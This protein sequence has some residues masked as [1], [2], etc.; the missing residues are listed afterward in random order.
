MIICPDVSSS[1]QDTHASFS[2]QHQS[3][4]PALGF[5][6]SAHL[7]RDEL[8]GPTSSCDHSRAY[9]TLIKKV[10]GFVE[11]YFQFQDVPCMAGKWLD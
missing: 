6:A 11:N 5:F 9:I 7:G 3:L 10:D 2:Q 8:E 4:L 1:F